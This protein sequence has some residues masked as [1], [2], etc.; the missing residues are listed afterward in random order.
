MYYYKMLIEDGI[1]QYMASSNE[2]INKQNLIEVN[3]QEY[4]EKTAVSSQP[5]ISVD[6]LIKQAMR[7]GYTVY[8]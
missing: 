5:V 1:W 3:E 8:E 4:I 2:P 7:S 6:S